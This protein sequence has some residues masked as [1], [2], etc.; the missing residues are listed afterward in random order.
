M[1]PIKRNQDIQKVNEND[2]INGYV[3]I[4]KSLFNCL[5]FPCRK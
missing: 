5:C 1:E 2:L 4:F 3:K